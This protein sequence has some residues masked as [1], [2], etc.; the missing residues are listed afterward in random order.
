MRNSAGGHEAKD[1]AKQIALLRSQLDDIAETLDGTKEGLLHRGQEA[2]EDTM[3]SARDLIA[4]Y[5]DS[6]KAMADN[7]LRLK[8]KAG[9]TLVAHSEDHPMT[10]IAAIL[11]IGMLAGWLLRRR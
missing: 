10:T 8:Q 9:D 7:A 2:L 11:G 3:Q 5:G 1:L 6:A 4:K